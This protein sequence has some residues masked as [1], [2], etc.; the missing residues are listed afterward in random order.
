MTIQIAPGAST[1]TAAYP[2][3]LM[4]IVRERGC[5]VDG[6]LEGVGLKMA[7]L[8]YEDARVSVTQYAAI[9]HAAMQCCE[10]EGLGYELAMR[11]PPTAHGPLG[12]AMMSSETCGDA[13]A[14]AL[15]YM[16]LMQ[17]RA[18]FDYSQD[19]SFA[20]LRPNITALPIPLPLRRFFSEA[21]MGGLVRSAAWLLGREKIDE[22]E[23]WLNYAEPPYFAK[24]ATQLPVVKHNA[25]FLQFCTP[26]A[27]LLRKLPL[28][29]SATRARAIAQCEYEITLLGMDGGN[30][31]ARVRTLLRAESG[32][33]PTADEVAAQLHLSRR[34]F[35]RRLSELGT[36]FRL[37]LEDARRFDAIT[38]L[39]KDHLSLERIAAEL[40]YGDPANFTRAF[41]RWTGKTPSAFR[42]AIPR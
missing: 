18:T 40:G 42:E 35:K 23:L 5:D 16:A 4:Q 20:Y 17:G 1:T 2:R 26:V 21:L 8:E 25:P 29:D 7:Q 14:L 28:A 12:L 30:F 13:L 10:D 6:L 31:T 9:A 27:T 24:Y 32:H 37:L 3:L 36:S 19:E 33:Y 11:T 39:Y 38:L 15:K 41:K 34:T 22:G